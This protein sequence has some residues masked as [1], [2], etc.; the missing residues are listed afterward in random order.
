MTMALV[1]RTSNSSTWG[2]YADCDDN[3][4]GTGANAD[5]VLGVGTGTVTFDASGQFL[6]ESGDN[7]SIALAG[8][9]VA[10]PLVVNPDFS[11]LT[12]LAAST[13]SELNVRSQDGAPTGTLY[14][15]AIGDD[16][17]IS[18]TFTN[19]LTESLGRLCVTRF[20]NNNG[21]VRD[22]DNLYGYGIN[23]GLPQDGEAMTGGRGAIRAGT[24]EGSNV[25]M[26]EEFTDMIVTQRGFQA[27]ARTITT[28]DQM[29]QELINLTR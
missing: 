24:L 5:L 3:A 2:W 21:L 26:A 12:Q 23:S 19:G 25:D 20:A 18:G 10:T 15:Y 9:G 28:S 22:A 27:N 8:A 1:S 29:L 16:G 6:S 7:I 17:T 4:A 11:P 14:S 13:G